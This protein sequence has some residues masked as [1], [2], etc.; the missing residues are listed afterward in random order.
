[1]KYDITYCVNN[2]ECKL[3]EK[4]QRAKFPDTKEKIWASMAEFYKENEECKN[5]KPINKL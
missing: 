1:M 3:R 2:E 5:Y 4:C